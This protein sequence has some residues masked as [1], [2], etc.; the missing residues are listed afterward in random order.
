MLKPS[1]RNVG[2]IARALIH[3]VRKHEMAF[4]HRNAQTCEGGA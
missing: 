2:S 4:N 3:N 1:P